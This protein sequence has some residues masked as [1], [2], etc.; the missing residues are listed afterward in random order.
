MKKRTVFIFACLL[1]AIVLIA[2]AAGG[3]EETS[4]V[5]LS[6][7]R[8]AFAGVFSK[9]AED[10]FGSIKTTASTA[11]DEALS[12]F[13]EN[14]DKRLA[15]AYIKA[16]GD[17]LDAK[18]AD[19]PSLIITNGGTLTELKKGDKI[20]G[21]AGAGVMLDSG[22]ATVCGNN[23]AELLN[24]GT[25]TVLKPGESVE[26]N[27]FYM[28]LDTANGGVEV[29]SETATLMIKDG[30]YIVKAY[31]PLYESSADT[32]FNLGLFRGTNNGY[33]LER[34]PTRQ[35]A[36][37][38]LIR[39]LGEEQFALEFDEKNMTFEDVTGWLDGRKY[40]AYGAYMKYTN[41]RSA[42]VFDQSGTAD[43]YM[44]LT[45]VLRAL[46]YSDAEGDFIWNRTSVDLAVQLGLLTQDEV[47]SIMI[48]GFKRDHVVLI[49]L[50]ALKKNLKGLD[51]TL[52]DKLVLDG[53]LTREQAD[54]L[55]D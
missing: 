28:I 7:I 52:A 11:V 29:T 37:I 46:R 50:N 8:E 1:T 4:L 51:L 32:L 30:S 20:I 27:V 10:T 31:V 5:S 45:F 18:I 2:L 19:D 54:S 42:K 17:K 15:D 25:G 55:L 33:E 43:I 3:D 48:T 9:N 13:E 36:L 44:Y 41:G 23:S 34:A 22:T 16:V 47:D 49:S 21:S 40:I 24:V 53:V 38:M 26:N 39:L 14:A 12:G 6:Y 35:E